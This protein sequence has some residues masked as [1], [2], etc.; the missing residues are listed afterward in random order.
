VR[1][2]LLVAETD[3]GDM[4]V[5]PVQAEFTVRGGLVTWIESMPED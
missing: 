1:L 5:E 3:A 4:A 2:R